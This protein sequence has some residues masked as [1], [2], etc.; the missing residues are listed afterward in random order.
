MNDPDRRDPA[1]SPSPNRRDFIAAAA[2]LGA[3]AALGGCAGADDAAPAAGV[4]SPPPGFDA[5]PQGRVVVVRADTREAAVARGLALMNGLTFIKPNQ[6][7]L[8]KPNFTGPMEPP[9]TTSPG[10]LV[11]LVRQCYAAGAADVIVAERAVSGLKT[12]AFFELKFYEGGAKS[13]KDYLDAAGATFL[14]LDDEPW[15]EVQPPG[16]VDYEAPIRIPKIL[17][18]VDHF[19]NV[20]A[21]KTH[22]IAV[23]TMSMKNLFGYVHPDVRL[24]QVHNSPKNDTDPDRQKR[25]FAQMNLAFSPVLNVMDAF[26][27]RTTGGPTPPGD[28]VDTRMVVLGRDRVAVD[29]VG[30]A[31]LRTVGSET[32]IED[33]PVWKQVF[34][35][36]AIKRGVG[37]GGPD[38]VTLVSEGVS[39]IATIEAKLR[40]V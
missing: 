2:V 40:E 26:V 34:L 35:A 3:S 23:F 5:V 37:V 10:V 25:M 6:R 21:L 18:E 36:E 31:I 22:S 33:R 17:S 11:E 16:A 20:P 13:M 19:I 7:V 15:V 28:V 8:L 27:S 30:L 9:D 29:A 4:G 24:G 38:E 12:R 1:T 14:P 32:W 39:E